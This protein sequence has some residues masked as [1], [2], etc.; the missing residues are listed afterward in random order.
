MQPSSYSE[1][2]ARRWAAR[3]AAYEEERRAVYSRLEAKLATAAELLRSQ[4][5]RQAWLYG[6]FLDG[7]WR[8]DSDVDLAVEPGPDFPRNLFRLEAALEDLLSQTVH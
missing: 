8:P 7:T 4:G 6:S 5:V 1:A 2:W 3:Q